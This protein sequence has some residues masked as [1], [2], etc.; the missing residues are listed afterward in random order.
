MGLSKDRPSIVQAVES[1]SRAGWEERFRSASS[2]LRDGK[3]FP[4]ASRPRG[5][6]PPRR[7]LLLD[8]ATIFRSLPIM[9]F[10]AFHSVCE[11]EFPAMRL[12]PFEAFPPPTAA[13][14]RRRISVSVRARV[15]GSTVSDRSVHREPCPLV[16]AFVATACGFPPRS[17]MRAGPRGLAPSSGPLLMRPLPAVRARCSLGLVRSVR[18]PSCSPP[19]HR[20]R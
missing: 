13:R 12:L 6:S 1:A 2:A 20:E 7:F 17:A 11:T 3:P 15:T 18:S 5:F 19:P 16:L 14:A 10:I 4:S 9:G 8:P